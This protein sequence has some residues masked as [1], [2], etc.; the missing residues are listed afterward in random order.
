MLNQNQVDRW[1]A[2]LP[3]DRCDWLKNVRGL[4]D[5]VI[6]EAKLGWDG[7]CFTI[8]IKDASGAWLF[9]KRRF[10]P[11]ND[12][13]GLR[14]KNA[15]GS[16]AALYG[17]E[18]I[19]DADMVVIA[20]GEFDA[21]VLR[22]K[23][24]VAVSST[25]G[26]NTFNPA[27]AE[28]F[29][30][31]PNVYVIYDYDDAGR[32]G[33][34]KVGS[35][36]PRA[37]IVHLPAEVGEKGDVTDY[38]MKLGKSMEDFQELLKTGKVVAEYEK[39]NVPAKDIAE[40]NL[41]EMLKLIP[42]DTPKYKLPKVLD[43]FF[44]ALAHESAANIFSMLRHAVKV[45]FDLTNEDIKAYEK[46]I[47]VYEKELAIKSQGEEDE[48]IEVYTDDESAAGKKIL[49]SPTLLH[50]FLSILKRSGLVGEERNALIH[51]LAF[52]S[53]LLKQPLSITVKGDSSAGKS[54]TLGKAMA[55]M[56]KSAYIDLT[57]ATPQSF[58]YGKPDQFKHR[59]VV[60]FERNGAER[61]DY[62]IRSLQSEGKLKIQVTVKN[63]ATG[64]FEAKTI[65]RE[66]PTGFITT[67]TA[68]QIH[69]E[70]ETRNLSIFPDQTTSQTERIYTVTNE[71]Y[72]GKNKLNESEIR[73]FQAAQTLIKGFSVLIPFAEGLEKHFP[74]EILRTR[75]DYARFLGIIEVS[76]LLHQEQREKIEK[77]GTTFLLATLAD[78]EIARCLTEYS[79]ARSIY[80]LPPRTSELLEV[81]P[82]LIKE[83][84]ASR[85]P[86]NNPYEDEDEDEEPSFTITDLAKYVKWDRDTVDRW[87][88][89][90]QKKTIVT[91]VEEAK[92]NKG[93]R[94]RLE[95]TVYHTDNFLPSVYVVASQNL[96]EPIDGIYNP[97]TGEPIDIQAVDT[98]TALQ[99]AGLISEVEEHGDLKIAV[100]PDALSEQSPPPDVPF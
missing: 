33:E 41:M 98:T 62:T 89:P 85:K 48:I 88:K 79:L 57:D 46:T 75:R 69:A 63:P 20:E 44:H 73:P 27:W 78:Y 2:N 80:E 29:E 25:G 32:D 37:K 66:G 67:T 87:L 35:L 49:Q 9:A 45:R 54:F 96:K 22:S 90:A 21:L 77:V 17:I 43:D 39:M 34:R 8:P 4:T 94:Y 3:E 92:G 18:F 53:R 95:D 51:C 64:V 74:K 84:R 100:A 11:E 15:V 60:I 28:L 58:Y 50:D 47:S 82:D 19:K 65:E 52:T 38:F 31:I 86:S 83:L 12:A 99:A 30:S 71:H 93:A 42:K 6:N 14:Y 72:L 16:T 59:I 1:H 81:I 40:S 5:E 24:F 23:G 76:T 61:A 56:P 97:L 68:S 55:L 10:P 7:G 36:I 70:N 91:R 13:N 26:A